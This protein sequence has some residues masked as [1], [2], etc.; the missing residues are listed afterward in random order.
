M[1]TVLPTAITDNEHNE[2]MNEGWRKV[3]E[4]L[5][6]NVDCSLTFIGAKIVW[7]IEIKLS[8]II[9]IY[10]SLIVMHSWEPSFFS[11]AILSK[12]QMHRPS[13]HSVPGTASSHCSLKKHSSPTST[14]NVSA[15]IDKHNKHL[16]FCFNCQG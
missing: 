9:Q 5:V 11:T 15:I 1:I 3:D 2:S 14:A 8:I 6:G 13:R 7:K 4:L 10:L 12:R 16:V